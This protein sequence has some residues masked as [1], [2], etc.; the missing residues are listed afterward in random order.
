[1]LTFGDIVDESDEFR[2]LKSSTIDFNIPEDGEKPLVDMWGYVV[3]DESN[4]LAFMEAEEAYNSSF[5]TESYEWVNNFGLRKPGFEWAWTDPLG[6]DSDSNRRIQVDYVGMDELA[7]IEAN[8]S[9]YKPGDIKL[10][11]D[12]KLVDPEKYD[13]RVEWGHQLIITLKEEGEII[14]TPESKVS[15]ELSDDVYDEEGVL[16]K[17]GH[18]FVDVNGQRL[19]AGEKVKVDNWAAF[20]Q[21]G[22]DFSEQIMLN[23]ETSVVK[24]KKITLEFYG[25]A[26]FSTDS[27]KATVPEKADFQFY[28]YDPARGVETSLTLSEE[29]IAVDGKKLVFTLSESV[30]SG[31]FVEATYDPSLSTFS[32]S[33]TEADNAFTN[34]NGVAAEPFYFLP[35]KNESPDEQGPHIM[36]ADVAGKMMHLQLEDPNGIYIGEAELSN[37]NLPNPSNFSLEATDSDNKTKKITA[38]SVI[39]NRW[40]DLEFQLDSAVTSTDV[41]KLTYSGNSLKDSLKNSSKIR[42]FEVWNNSVDFSFEDA[43]SWFLLNDLTNVVFNDGLYIQDNGNVSSLSS[44]FQF[45]DE[46]VFKLK[47]FSKVTIDLTDVNGETLDDDGDANLDFVLENER[48]FDYVGGSFNSKQDDWQ[49]SPTN[50]E[51]NVSFQLP[52]GEWRL[53]VEHGETWNEISQDYQLKI[54]TSAATFEAE[55]TFTEDSTSH[56]F[57]VSLDNYRK[58]KIFNVDVAGNLTFSLTTPEDFEGDVFMNLFDLGGQWLNESWTGTFSQYVEAGSYRLEINSWTPPTPGLE[59]PSVAISATLDTSISLDVDT[60]TK[61]STSGSI[62]VDGVPTEGEL[63][64]L[65]PEDWW[66]LKLNGGK[67]YTL[68][69]TDFTEDVNLVALNNL[70]NYE[71]WS[72]NWG[73]ETVN[74]DG[75]FTFTPSDETLL[76]DLST[77][78]YESGKTYQFTVNPHIYSFNPTSYSLIAKSHDTLEAAQTEISTGIVSYDD[79]FDSFFGETSD[80]S[81][82]VKIDKND[83]MGLAKL[84]E[85]TTDEVNTLKA[86]LEKELGAMGQ[87]LSGNP[88]AFKSSLT[89]E[90]G[91]STSSTVAVV[92]TKDVPESVSDQVSS[93]NITE[94]NNNEPAEL[95]STGSTEEFGAKEISELGNDTK[96]EAEDLTP[97]SQPVDVSARS[98]SST[99]SGFLAEGNP[100]NALQGENFN[101]NHASTTQDLGLQRIGIQLSDEIIAQLSDP[102]ETRDLIWYRKPNNGDAFIFTYD[103]TTGTGALLED[104]DSNG[105]NDVMALYVR[106]GGRG[107]DDKQVNGEIVS[108][109]GLAFASLT[110]AAPDTT[111]TTVINEDG[112]AVEVETVLWKLDVDSDGIINALADGLAITRRHLEGSLETDPVLNQLV[113]TSGERT[114]ESS[115]RKYLD[116]GIQ[117]PDKVLDIDNSGTFDTSDLALILR[118][119]T[120]TFPSTSLSNGF[121]NDTVTHAD[122]IENLNSLISDQQVT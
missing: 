73:T 56:D 52:A 72:V 46:Y 71:E 95:T 44:N 20:S 105:T 17:A 33:S 88:I 55:K 23:P 12:K 116:L 64:S 15:F 101:S 24:G 53:I 27:E 59:A 3:F 76:F 7:K 38:T 83:L 81:D 26:D 108:P 40:G 98:R 10:K 11:I 54:S 30:P 51:R 120:G 66:T 31:T 78:K 36:Y 109:G 75:S 1:M 57:N 94:L 85:P 117:T 22:F 96:D 14:L 13:V 34:L 107:D 121:S 114:T 28:S 103:S 6:P 82:S 47:E 18:G 16:T 102:E 74:D 80:S 90:D 62:T 45:I 60:D 8:G 2:T 43:N 118:Q 92:V 50:D 70:L 86:A 63:N 111:T 35:L 89:S 122:I 4:D 106:D 115:V 104:S 100:G 119:A 77:D 9:T 68:R 48:T 58:E 61:D 84:T 69:A 87:E 5:H 29:D 25:D 19:E 41:V 91:S 32:D 93:E 113:S 21:M 110:A 49:E 42:D 65:D 67:I 97:I 39:L 99:L 37:E 79:I 112:V